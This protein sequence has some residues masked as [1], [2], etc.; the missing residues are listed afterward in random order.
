MSHSQSET[1]Y[2][3]THLLFQE[4]SKHFD[5]SSEFFH[6]FL[7]R[8]DQSHLCSEIAFLVVASKQFPFGRFDLCLASRVR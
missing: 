5:P 4:A 3:E 8:L 7:F 6:P 2:P 1:S